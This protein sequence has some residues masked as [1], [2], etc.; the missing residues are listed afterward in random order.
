MRSAVTFLTF[1][2]IVASFA[3]ATDWPAFRGPQGNGISE[4]TQAPLEWNKTKNIKWQAKLPQA[5]NGSPIVSNGVVFVA[6]T[7]DPKGK[8]RSLYAFDRKSGDQLWMKTVS[9]EKDDPTHNTNPHGSSTPAADGKRVVVWHGSGGLYCYDFKGNELWKQEL[10]EFR[11]MWGYGS[12]PVIHND[13][14]ILHSGP[15]KQIFVAAYALTDGSELWKT[16]EPQ[17]GDGEHRTKDKAYMGSWSTPVI[18]KLDGKEQAICTLPTRVVSYDLT[19]G[20]MLWSCDGIRGPKG[21][22][23]YSSPVIAGDVCVS[24]GGFGGPAIGFKLGGEGDITESQRL[25]RKDSNPQS[26]GSGVVIDGY[27]HRPENGGSEMDRARW[28]LLGLNRVRRRPLLRDRSGWHNH[29]IQ[30]VA[31]KIRAARQE[32]AG[33]SK[34]RD[35]S[36]F[37][38]R[39][40][41]PHAQ[42]AVLH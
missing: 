23:A 4:E 30:A 35:T 34:Q 31:G 20:K 2:C 28:E 41:H 14:V 39:V 8:Q 32:S 27:F 18:V 38:W 1:V 16:E 37:R 10:G 26:I 6:C 21:D 29:S 33:G 25:W 5:G 42:D 24:T 3:C 12:S 13:R 19:D 22:L 40:L 11:H 7:E 36:N 15:G 17:E 9:Y